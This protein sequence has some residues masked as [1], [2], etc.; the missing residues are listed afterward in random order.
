MQHQIW[1]KFI[2]SKMSQSELQSDVSSFQNVRAESSGEKVLHLPLKRYAFDIMITEEKASEFRRAGDWIEKR[3]FETPSQDKKGKK[4]KKPQE[5]VHET[6]VPEDRMDL[7]AELQKEMGMEN[8]GST[9]SWPQPANSQKNS[10]Q[11]QEENNSEN[12]VPIPIKKDYKR[13]TYH[14]VEFRNGYGKNVQ[15]FRCAYGGF[16]FREFVPERKFSNGL[17]CGGTDLYEIQLGP[18]T[19]AG[20]LKK[21]LVDLNP[22]LLEIP[23]VRD[24][25]VY[26]KIDSKKAGTKRKKQHGMASFDSSWLSSEVGGS[27]SVAYPNSLPS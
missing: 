19:E 14:I 10:N 9:S 17:R 18:V 7:F 1:S 6:Y 12:D 4:K 2:T 22:Q 15:W 5:S 20:N 13:K 23:G 16:S 25:I 11:N 8:I 24:T 3:L 21:E 27:S 26:P